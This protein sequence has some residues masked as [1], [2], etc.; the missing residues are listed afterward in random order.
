[1]SEQSTSTNSS[2]PIEKAKNTSESKK[3]DNKKDDDGMFECN[4]CFEPAQEPVVTVCGH[5]FW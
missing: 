3:D 5:L 4:I 1:M 2:P